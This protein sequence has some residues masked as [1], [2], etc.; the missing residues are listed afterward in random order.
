MLK[1]FLTGNQNARRIF[2][3]KELGIILKQL[4][5]RPL[6]QSERNRLSRDIKPKLDFIKEIFEFGD[7]FGLR[8]NQDNKRIMEKAVDA[9]LKDELGQSVAAVL[10]FGSFADNT[11]TSNSDIDICAVLKKDVSLRDAT[12]F[13]IRVSGQLPK[14][15]DIQVFNALPQK[16]KKEIAKNHKV[17]YQ[18]RNYDNTDFT[19]KYLKDHDYFLRIK[20]IF[21]ADAWAG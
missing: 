6:T 16:V 8:K 11:F 12:R 19:I 4:D 21:G 9:V 15:A 10:L 3:K 20:K 2:G 14:K 17:L 18:S 1:K 7:E 13:R 5:G